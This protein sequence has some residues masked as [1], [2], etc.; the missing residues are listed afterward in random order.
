MD[1]TIALVTAIIGTLVSV[2]ASLLTKFFSDKTLFGKSKIKIGGVE[3][4]LT[5]SADESTRKILDRVQE[6]QESPQVFL[7]YSFQ[8]KEFAQRLASDLKNAGVKVWLADE[9]V[10]VGD[11]IIDTI[12]DGISTSQWIIVI[13]S[14]NSSQSNYVSKE[15]TFALDEEQKRDR[16]FILPIMI[17]DTILPAPLQDKQ[18]ADFRNDYLLGLEKILARVKPPKP[19]TG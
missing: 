18:Y 5:E 11:R 4:Q 12:R 9:Q 16:P 8:D 2:L 3:F 14:E 7:S 1:I 10:K 15:L 17:G 6:L 19:K 13:L